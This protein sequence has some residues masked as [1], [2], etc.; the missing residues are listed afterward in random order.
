MIPIFSALA[1]RRLNGSH[2]PLTTH[3]E[4]LLTAVAQAVGAATL[5]QG[6]LS[7][8]RNSG[9]IYGSMDKPPMILMCLPH[10]TYGL[11]MVYIWSIYGLYMVSKWIIMMIIYG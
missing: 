9:I 1:A 10:D 3:E 6:L 8:G 11:Y 5:Q 7:R 2:P 4:Q